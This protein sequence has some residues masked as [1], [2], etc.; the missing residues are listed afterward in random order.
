MELVKT[1]KT[2]KE[3]AKDLYISEHTV[4]AH[5]SAILEKTGC[6]NRVTLAVYSEKLFGDKSI[7]NYLLN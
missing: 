6:R 7:E 2:N 5:I 4:K 1:G 3:I